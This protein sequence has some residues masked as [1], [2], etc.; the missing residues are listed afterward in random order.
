MNRVAGRPALMLLLRRAEILEKLAVDEFELTAGQKDRDHPRNTVHD[1]TRIV[2]AVA[3]GLFGALAIVDVDQQVKPAEDAPVRIPQRQAN[4]VE[5]AV[6]AVG[7]TMAAFDVVRTA[8]LV[9]IQLC[10]DCPR[11]VI[12]V[13]D[14]GGLPAFQLLER[15]A[16]VVE[17]S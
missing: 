3:Q 1:Q 7:A 11:Q 6:D 2:L 12:R 10:G 5:P 16:E 8:P 14:V 15:L 4:D 13:D 9:R 17:V